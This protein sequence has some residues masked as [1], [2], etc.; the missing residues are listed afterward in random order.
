MIKNSIKEI[1]INFV[2]NIVVWI[3]VLITII[4]PKTHYD[5]YKRRTTKSVKN[6]KGQR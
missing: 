4:N 1:L 6:Y 5:N 3:L 2:F